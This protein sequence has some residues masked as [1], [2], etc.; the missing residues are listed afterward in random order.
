MEVKIEVKGALLVLAGSEH[1]PKGKLD[2]S[3]QIHLYGFT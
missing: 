2:P 1:V 3:R